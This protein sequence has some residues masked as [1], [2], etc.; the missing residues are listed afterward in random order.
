LNPVDLQL[1]QTGSSGAIKAGE[2]LTYPLQVTNLNTIGNASQVHLTVTLPASTS[3]VS[4]PPSC[5]VSAGQM[6][7]SISILPPQASQSYSLVVRVDPLYR[8]ATILSTAVVDSE[9]I[10]AV[11]AANNSASVSTSVSARVALSITQSLADTDL[12]VGGSA[13]VVVRVVNDGPSAATGLVITDVVPSGLSLSTAN[14]ASCDATTGTVRCTVATLDAGAQ[15]MITL[16]L[17]AQNELG[18][19]VTHT[20]RVAANEPET[21]LADNVASLALRLNPIDLSI[22]QS[23]DGSFVA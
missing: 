19:S 5:S 22:Q 10:E 11:N 3:V 6:L 8:G 2:L 18:A 9:Q 21:N 4:A 16:T 7:C 12:Y 15:A 14:G 13:D 20:L 1:T 23:A 17:Q